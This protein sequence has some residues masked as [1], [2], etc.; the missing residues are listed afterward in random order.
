[1]TVGAPTEHLKQHRRPSGNNCSTGP[2]TAAGEAGGNAKPD[3]G[4]RK[5][6]IP[7]RSGLSSKR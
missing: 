5:L 2:R 7:T 6:G 3:G 4:V 1:M